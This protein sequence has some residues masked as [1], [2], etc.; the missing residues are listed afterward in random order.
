MDAHFIPSSPASPVYVVIYLFIYLFY[1]GTG[2]ELRASPLLG[3]CSYCLNL[4]MR[5]KL[6]MR[7]IF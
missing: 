5:E 1:C 2:L 4:L 3:R 6:L 7:K